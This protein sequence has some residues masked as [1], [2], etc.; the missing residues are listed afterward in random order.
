MKIFR[1]F[2]LL[3]TFSLASICGGAE[4]RVSVSDLMAD[5]LEEQ[6][7]DL[8]NQ[9]SIE[10]TFSKE[11]SLPALERLASDESD[12]VVIAIPEGHSM[13][14]AARYATYPLAHDI[15]VIVVNE[16][17]PIG[18]V[19]LAQLGGIFGNNETFDYKT[20]GELGLSGWTGRGIKAIAA[21]SASSISNEIFKYTALSSNTFKSAVNLVDVASAQKAISADVSCIGLVSRKTD[22]RRTKTLMISA[23]DGLPAYGPS[24]DNV[25]YGDYPLRLPFYGVFVIATNDR[26]K[27]RLSYLL[28]ENCSQVL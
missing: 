19:S 17:N 12:I 13:P 2:G 3:G 22:S 4:L 24:V 8:A 28:R 18:E 6:L 21:E 23:G 27:P 14:D 11:G 9:N 20:W 1:I 25:H 10:M 7:T 26:V 16:D 5:S 15:A